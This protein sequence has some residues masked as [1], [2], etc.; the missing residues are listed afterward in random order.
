MHCHGLFSC[1]GRM[2]RYQLAAA[3]ASIVLVAAPPGTASAE[4]GVEADPPR[5]DAL[6]FE[7]LAFV[8]SDV[9]LLAQGFD[10]NGY[11]V[12]DI[13]LVPDATKSLEAETIRLLNT[14]VTFAIGSTSLTSARLVEPITQGQFRLSGGLSL[15]ETRALAGQIICAMRLSADQYDPPSLARDLPCNLSDKK[16]DGQ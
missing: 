15:G 4:P 5:A 16:G 7:R 10:D 2:S 3:V 6:Y 14:D 1:L 13:A 11:P 8:R 9:A 12:L